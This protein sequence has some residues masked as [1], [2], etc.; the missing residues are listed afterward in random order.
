[1]ASVHDQ[2]KRKRPPTR[3]DGERQPERDEDDEHPVQVPHRPLPS[4]RAHWARTRVRSPARPSG[5]ARSGALAR[6]SRPLLAE[7]GVV[8]L[9]RPTCRRSSRVRLLRRPRLERN[10]GLRASSGHWLAPNDSPTVP[11]WPQP[12]ASNRSEPDH[13]RSRPVEPVQQAA[14]PDHPPR[15]PDQSSRPPA[16]ASTRAPPAGARN[17]GDRPRTDCGPRV[18]ESGSPRSCHKAAPP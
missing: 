9:S 17:G 5:P 16:Q 2:R 7:I 4:G 10:R 14:H 6:S 8:A 3:A 11:E 18:T 15:S 13:A 12:P 1:M